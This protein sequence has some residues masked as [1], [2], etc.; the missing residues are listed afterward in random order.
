LSAA[1]NENAP[2]INPHD[3]SEFSLPPI[4]DPN[5]VP[6]DLFTPARLLR[7]QMKNISIGTDELFPKGTWPEYFAVLALAALGELHRLTEDKINI[8]TVALAA[9]AMEA[10]T[11]AESPELVG[12]MLTGDH[13][14]KVSIQNKRNAIQGHA[15]INRWKGLFR[16]WLAEEHLPSLNG[17][18]LNKQEA[19][20]LY[21]DEFIDP[22]INNGVAPELNDVKDIIRLLVNSLADSPRFSEL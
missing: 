8:A 22:L 11:I 14:K 9:E 13:R 12:P 1:I 21:K 15:A 2:L 19:A 5:C 10:L 17:R 18:P 20:R 4:T 3:D 16:K 6:L 7:S